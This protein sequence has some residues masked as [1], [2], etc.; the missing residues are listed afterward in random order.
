MKFEEYK[1]SIKTCLER[2]VLC[3][4][5]ANNLLLQSPPFARDILIRQEK[6]R[7]VWTLLLECMESREGKLAAAEQLHKFN[8]DVNETNDRLREKQMGLSTELGRDTKHAD[9]LIQKH[10]VYEN[11]VTQLHEQLKVGYMI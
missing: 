5:S 3:E 11:E 10:V 1:Q 7:A 2:F 4:Q 8:R 6:L 9:S